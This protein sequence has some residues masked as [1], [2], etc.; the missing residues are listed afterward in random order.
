M[1]DGQKV[2]CSLNS[3]LFIS[4]S[5]VWLKE[6]KFFKDKSS[7]IWFATG[8]DRKL[9]KMIMRCRRPGQM[10]VVGK[11]EY[12][13]VIEASMVSVIPACFLCM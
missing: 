11:P 10:L 1:A 6:F 13:T 12:R 2:I 8:A 3:S 5:V 9:S 4:L 7:A